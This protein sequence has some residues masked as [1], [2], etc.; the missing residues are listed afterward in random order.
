[1]IYIKVSSDTAANGSFHVGVTPPMFYFSFLFEWLQHRL[2]INVEGGGISIPP[3]APKLGFI[4]LK[5][6]V[7]QNF[8]KFSY[9]SVGYKTR[10]VYM[11]RSSK[12]CH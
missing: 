8:R 10:H 4:S 2:G 1:L 12:C 7:S 6:E 11:R 5:F 9:G 3:H